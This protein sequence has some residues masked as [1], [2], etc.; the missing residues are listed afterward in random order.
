MGEW[1]LQED[2]DVTEKEKKKKKEK[3]KKT[4]GFISQLVRCFSS[5]ISTH[6]HTH[7]HTHAHAHAHTHTHTHTHS[8][9]LSRKGIH[10]VIGS[11]PRSFLTCF[12]QAGSLNRTSKRKVCIFNV[13]IVF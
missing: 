12:V 8:S 10:L 7:T 13:I 1:E 6:T 11:I 9:K 5:Q 3:R 2:G 4:V